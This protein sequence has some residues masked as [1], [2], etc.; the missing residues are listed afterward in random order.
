MKRFL[1]LGLFALGLLLAQFAFSASASATCGTGVGTCYGIATGNWNANGTWSATSGGLSC[2][3]TPA[4]GD[5]IILDTNSNGFTFTISVSISISTLNATCTCTVVPGNATTLTITG[6]T[7]SLGSGVTWQAANATRIITFTS[8]SGT[9]TI[10]MAGSATQYLGAVNFGGT[11]GD[12]VLAGPFIANSAVTLTAG[13]L[14]ASVNN[15]NLTLST[16]VGS[17]GT[18]L[19]CGTGTWTM[20]AASGT[21]WSHLGTLSCASAAFVFANS[22]PTGART[23]A[24]NGGSFGSVALSGGAGASTNFPVAITGAATFG[25]FPITPPVNVEWPGG[26]TI[27]ITNAPT[28]NGTASTPL[29][30]NTTGGGGAVAT[31]AITNGTPVMN[32]IGFNNMKFTGNAFNAVNSFDL[33]LNDSGGTSLTIVPP[34]VGGGH[35]IGG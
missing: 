11:G 35:I 1:R 4:T 19:N 16:F 29:F 10:T 14:D 15:V 6:N 28:W 26:V 27:T 2:A 7:F 30:F 20:T 3:C 13:T 5:A 9:T 18:T 12:F 24:T 22:T 32:W 17:A 25:T 21:A 34:S 23:F 33:G 31:L 8:T